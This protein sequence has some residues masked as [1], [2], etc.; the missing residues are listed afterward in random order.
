M[1]VSIFRSRS[2]VLL[3]A[4][5]CVSLPLSLRAQMNNP[6][7]QSPGFEKPNAPS[8]PTA[9]KLP[10]T[11][12]IT[13]DGKVVE[14]VIARVNDQI[15]SRSDLERSQ[16]QL[17]AELAQTHAPDGD[18]RMRNL[19]RDLIDQQL[20]LSKGKDMGINVDAEVVRR[21]D[22]IRKQNHIA[23]MEDL[24]KAARA[25]GVSFEDFKASIRN[26]LITQSVVRDEVGRN[27]HITMADLRK[28][29]D[30][31]KDAFVQ[32]EQIR[33]SEILIPVAA[34]ADPAAVDAAHK[35]ADD[36]ISKLAG[37][38]KF[39]DVAKEMSGGPTA[40]QGGD[41]GLFKR[42]ALAPILEEKT[43]V[44]KAGEHTEP[45]RTRQGFVVLQTVEHQ[46][47]G[48][49]EMEQ[50]MPQL[51]EAMYGE[52]MAPA[53]RT[54]LTKLREDAY[55]D[56]KP[57]F[58]DTGASDKQTKPI[59]TAYA[60]PAPKKKTQEV[61][62]RFDNHRAGSGG[63]TLQ[64][65]TI[66]LDK[67]GKPK[68][69]KREKIR[70][71]QA[72]RLALPAGPVDATTQTDSA[73]ATP[74]VPT[75]ANNTINADDPLAPV[76]KPQ[77][78]GRFSHTEA[79]VKAKKV[80]EV[81]RKVADKIA[82]TPKAASTEEVTDKKVQAAPLGLNGDTSK[83]KQKR[84]KNA[85]KER[86]QGKEPEKKAPLVQNPL[87]DKNTGLPPEQKP[88]G[89]TTKPTADTTTLPPANAPAPGS[90][91]PTPAAPGQPSTTSNQPVPTGSQQ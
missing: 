86:L 85:P 56:I 23:N 51:Q 11:A 1:T 52:A 71:G 79:E 82:A 21:L 77:K 69:L 31:H 59:F 65:T 50:I 84:D 35:K 53:L 45:I 81:N 64:G 26:N 58:V 88:A 90:L 87:P 30:A 3:A 62:Q 74:A 27:L 63:A 8:T 41:L 57:G 2:S 6:R 46:A 16:G 91:T 70:Y 25:Q 42:G 38:A 61:K 39:A 15:I 76:S 17:A 72:P 54:Y 10:E 13:P 75:E 47:A 7:Y 36:V 60:P 28:F 40:S 5:M 19:L 37:G 9:P 22:D 67:H 33:L 68:K 55:V 44:L 43:F 48:A 29:Y 14:D 73:A 78:R 89:S 20:L 4:A 80:N 34:D 24:E 83:K 18:D 49:P 66:E 32:P 12:A